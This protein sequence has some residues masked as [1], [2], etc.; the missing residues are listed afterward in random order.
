[1]IVVTAYLLLTMLFSGSLVYLMALCGALVA[2]RALDPQPSGVSISPVGI[3]AL[4][5]QR[6]DDR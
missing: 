4:H 6:R 2:D 5:V 1:M 3:S